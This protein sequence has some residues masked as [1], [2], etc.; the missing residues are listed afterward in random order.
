MIISALGRRDDR[1]LC[2]LVNIHE[3]TQLLAKLKV[4]VDGS[5]SFDKGWKH[6]PLDENH[7]AVA[8]YDYIVVLQRVS[9]RVQSSP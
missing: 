4:G 2:P 6:L 3:Y 8:G 7:M 1:Q 5:L 9:G